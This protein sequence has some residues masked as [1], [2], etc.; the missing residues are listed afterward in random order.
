[1]KNILLTIAVLASLNVSTDARKYP[2]QDPKLPV[3]QR[4]ED[5]LGRM[6]LE[7]KVNQMSAQLLF[8]DEFFEKRDYAKGHVRNIGHFLWDFK[9]S[10]SVFNSLCLK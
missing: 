3:E 2:Y 9:N 7:E 1:M 4:V 5:L 6:S 10:A 8:M